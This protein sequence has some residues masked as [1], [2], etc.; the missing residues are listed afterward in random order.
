[1]VFIKQLPVPLDQ[2]FIIE[3]LKISKV[4]TSLLRA[5]G[6]QYPTILQLNKNEPIKVQAKSGNWLHVM[7]KDSVAG[8][9][10]M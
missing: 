2:T 10:F 7:A 3:P 6:S 8:F 4:N 1:M 5:P 9:V